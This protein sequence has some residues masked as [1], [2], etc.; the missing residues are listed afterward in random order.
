MV[1]PLET[2]SRRWKSPWGTVKVTAIGCTWLTLMMPVV[3]PVVTMLPGSTSRTPT[4]PEIGE[5]MR[6]NFTFCAAAA[7]EP[8]SASTVP[9]SCFTVAAW[10]SAVC[11]AIEFCATS[12]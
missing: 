6:Q 12:V 2:V 3:R 5:G 9:S 1:K 4:R 8:W 11:L 7:T 10:S